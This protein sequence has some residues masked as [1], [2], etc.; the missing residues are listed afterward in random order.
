MLSTVQAH[1]DAAA[2]Q[3]DETAFVQHSAQIK[4]GLTSFS[5]AAST[6][7]SSCMSDVSSLTDQVQQHNTSM[8]DTFKQ[9]SQVGR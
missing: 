3:D 7:V 8:Q 2:L 1:G 5:S 4:D 6:A 9:Q